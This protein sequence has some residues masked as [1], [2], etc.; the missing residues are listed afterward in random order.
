MSIDFNAHAV[1]A[2]KRHVNSVYSNNY[3]KLT[4]TD[5]TQTM[6]QNSNCH[7]GRYS[8]HLNA[9][10]FTRQRIKVMR[11]RSDCQALDIMFTRLLE[12]Y[13]SMSSHISPSRC[14]SGIKPIIHRI[15]LMRKS[16]R[17]HLDIGRVATAPA[18]QPIANHPPHDCHVKQTWWIIG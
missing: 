12:A 13:Q 18:C 6:I 7:K 15:F 1:H 11:P 5:N 17:R 4:Y 8:G 3:R 16:R 14:Q 9:K 2:R 10:L